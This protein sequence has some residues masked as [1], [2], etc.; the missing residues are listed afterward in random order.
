[1]FRLNSLGRSGTII[2]MANSPQDLIATL[3]TRFGYDSFR[4]P[5][6]DIIRRLLGGGDCI[7]LMPTGGGKSL[8]YQLPALIKEGTALVISPLISLMKDQVNALKANGIPAAYYNSS[9]S[10]EE[11]S[12]VAESAR[13]GE[14][15]L[16][17]VSP[18]RALSPH[19]A[20]L[21][22]D[23]VVSLLAIDEAHCVSSWGHSFRPEY[24]QLH[25][26]VASLPGIPVAALTATADRAVRS[27]IGEM[28][29]MRE[30]E[31]FVSSFDRPNISLNVL[32]GQ[33]KFRQIQA[34]LSRHLL[35]SGIIYC[36][37]RKSCEQL[38]EKLIAAGHRARAY[39]AGM[40]AS[41]REEV[42]DRFIDGRD[43]IICA[44]IAFGMG[45][46][47]PDI[48][49][50]IHYNMPGNLESYY[51]EIGRSGRDGDP[52]EAYLFYSYRDVQ[53]QQGFIDAIGDAEYRKIQAAKLQRMQEYAESAVCRRRVLLSYFSEVMHEPCGNCDVCANP[54]EYFNGT[55]HAQKALSAVIRSRETLPV[56]LLVDV[57]RGASTR[58]VGELGLHRIKTYGAGRDT[59]AFAWQLYL[60]QMIQ[61]GILELD[62]RDSFRLKLT[63][64]SRPI[65]SGDREVDLISFE[66]IKRRQEELKKRP[67]AFPGAGEAEFDPDLFEELRRYRLAIARELG[68]P[69]FVVFSDATLRDMAARKPKSEAEFLAVKG[70]GEHKAKIYG[71]GFLQLIGE[72]E[73]GAG[74]GE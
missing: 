72:Y 35:E 63:E 71:S 58:E 5:Q 54:P 56:S 48:R 47:K 2:D 42:H 21:M 50:V 61:Q 51:Q 10:D 62:Y 6:E 66:T 69:P 28:L 13:G 44:T 53:T 30:P 14:L 65:L 11:A 4:G 36:S 16:L 33:Q 46:D 9:L 19:F 60:Q 68:K 20:G 34:I 24:R 31:R 38:A 41:D 43:S 15:K 26:L 73:G 7:I 27:D 37:S 70:V 49:F 57:L 22:K 67:A 18:E 3:K 12:N 29:G 55:I 1:M 52:A 39:H 25:R 74:A 32:P 59:S 8:C 64:L 40:S 45:I 23:M 17:Y